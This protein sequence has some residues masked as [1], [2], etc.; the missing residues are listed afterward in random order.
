MGLCDTKA[1][2]VLMVINSITVLVGVLVIVCGVMGICKQGK[3]DDYTGGVDI[4]F[5]CYG[6]LVTGVVILIV[7]LIG[8][9]AGFS[10]NLTIAKTYVVLII[11]ITLLQLAFCVVEYLKRGSI[12][13]EVEGYMNETFNGTVYTDLPPMQQDVVDLIQTNLE[14]CGLESFNDWTGPLPASCCSNSTMNANGTMNG[15][16]TTPSAFSLEPFVC[17]GAS[18]YE[19]GCRAEGQAFA[20]S[21]LMLSVIILAVGFLLE[22]ICIFAGFWVTRQVSEYKRV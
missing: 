5:I 2:I 7:G 10:G 15:N 13:M 19:A 8:W 16:G 11:I 17:N 18:A 1:N 4:E 12:S 22:F 3:L 9:Y 14:C 6:V 21:A 20:S